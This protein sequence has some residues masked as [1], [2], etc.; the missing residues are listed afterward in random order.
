MGPSQEG[1]SLEE[2]TTTEIT[3]RVIP[4]KA[5]LFMEWTEDVGAHELCVADPVVRNTTTTVDSREGVEI[6]DVRETIW[7]RRFA[8]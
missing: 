6:I 5:R 7:R 3:F 2:E 1:G 4:S 8:A